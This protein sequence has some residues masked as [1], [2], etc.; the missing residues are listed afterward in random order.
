MTGAKLQLPLNL[1]ASRR[2]VRERK[3]M[4]AM[5][6]CY[7]HDCHATAVGLCPE[8]RGLLDYATLRLDGCRFGAGKPTCAHCP[9]HCYQRNRRDQ[10]KN[11]MWHAGPRMLCRHPI[12][13]LRHW[14]DGF[15]KVPPMNR[16]AAYTGNL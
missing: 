10:M 3:T 6:C 5:I 8:C 7:C 14:L 16:N 12:W 15:R 11:V 1:S 9:V 2:L 4:A 13:S